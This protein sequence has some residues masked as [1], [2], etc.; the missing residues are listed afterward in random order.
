MNFPVISHIFFSYP[1]KTNIIISSIL[2][3]RTLRYRYAEKL[4]E[5]GFEFSSVL[6]LIL[7]VSLEYKKA[8]FKYKK[9][10]V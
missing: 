8:H 10:A 2:L 5:L 1:Y 6:L 9:E 7:S 4:V 3:V